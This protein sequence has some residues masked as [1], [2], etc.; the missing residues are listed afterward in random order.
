MRL[1]W[2]K[3]LFL[4]TFICVPLSGFGQQ[5]NSLVRV[6]FLHVNDVYQFMPVDGGTRRRT[7]AV[8]DAQKRSVKGKSAYAFYTR[9]RHDFAVGGNAHLQRRTDD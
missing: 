2:M 3:F 7:C 8:V 9:R 6:T 1:F 4:L 5:N